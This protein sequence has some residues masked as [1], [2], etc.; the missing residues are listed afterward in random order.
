MNGLRVG[1]SLAAGLAVTAVLALGSTNPAAAE[2]ADRAGPATVTAEPTRSASIVDFFNKWM[3]CED[4]W[5]VALDQM[6]P[7]DFSVGECMDV[8]EASTNP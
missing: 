8:I 4:T 7:D 2:D 5:L 3:F 1:R 6:Y